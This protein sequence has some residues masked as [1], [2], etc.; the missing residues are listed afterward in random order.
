VKAGVFMW[1][2]EF[3]SIL[4]IILYMAY[5]IY[6]CADVQLQKFIRL[7]DEFDVAISK[8]DRDSLFIQIEGHAYYWFWLEITQNGGRFE[9]KQSF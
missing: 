1:I 7:A 8:L 4:R 3:K 5:R 9:P 6:A 2:K